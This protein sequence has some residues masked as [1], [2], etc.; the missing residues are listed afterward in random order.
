VLID[1]ILSVET[2][3]TAYSVAEIGELL[4]WLAAA[5]RSSSAEPE[6]VSCIPAIRR[7]E[8]RNH[9]PRVF[10]CDMDLA[11]ETISRSDK[12]QNGHCWHDIFSGPVL[13]RGYPIPRR[14]TLA[15]GSG[16]EIPLDML[17]ALVD[18]SCIAEFDNR[19]FIKGYSAL[20]IPTKQVED[21][22]IWHLL[23]NEDG[24]RISYTDSRIADV[25]P[26][27]PVGIKA[28]R[29]ILGWCSKVRNHTGS[30]HANYDIKWSGLGKPRERHAWEKVSISGGD[31][32]SI[33]TS[34]VIGK[35]DRPLF[36]CAQIGYRSRLRFIA[37]QYVVLY[38]LEEKRAWLVDGLSALLHLV[39]ASLEHDSKDAFNSFFLYKRGQLQEAHSSK[40]GPDAAATVLFNPANCSLRLFPED[41]ESW[42]EETEKK[43]SETETVKEIVS[44]KRVTFFCLKD[45]VLE[46]FS[47]L[48]RIID[49]LNNVQ[50]ETGVGFRL[51][52]TPR[53]TL[54]GFDF[55]DVATNNTPLLPH[56]VKLNI[57][58]SGRGWVDLAR[59]LQAITLFGKG[60]DELISPVPG[61]AQG[62][63]DGCG[64]GVS[65]PVGK[66]YLATCV[67]VVERIL[68]TRGST[69]TVPWR[70]ADDIYW[71]TPGAVFEPCQCAGSGPRKSDRAQVL[72]PSLFPKMWGRGF[73]SPNW[74]ESQGGIIFS[75]N[76][77]V[78]FRLGHRS[79]GSQP[80][81]QDRSLLEAADS[82]LG[83]SLTSNSGHSEDP[84]PSADGTQ[85]EA[86][87]NANA[88]PPSSPVVSP[89]QQDS[90]LPLE[91]LPLRAT[92]SLP[93]CPT[94]VLKLP[95]RD[96]NSADINFGLPASPI[97]RK[98]K[99]DRLKDIAE[100]FRG[101]IR[102]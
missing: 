77:K 92:T 25:E 60:F 18:A 38:D 2:S 8:P 39:R 59:S 80:I 49:N 3:G 99:A 13:V 64:Y 63:C 67:D 5:L 56:L 91:S 20:L 78:P 79:H 101:K 44:K 82:G 10:E 48:E 47:L 24:S 36:G 81:A 88:T 35:K 58:E 27:N 45:R 11:M 100:Q 102:R 68:A 97:D 96:T 9:A 33:G 76:W 57:S 94:N 37:K 43:N 41:E 55:M 71:H 85:G 4:G 62:A 42:D 87:D 16:L 93:S 86:S 28:A 69:E 30:P 15:A 53:N 6:M 23:F 21:V 90:V 1:G 32:V 50:S 72:L 70:L 40:Y 34:F 29:H 89:R 98:R 14:E 73:A 74:L 61:D 12:P 52:G 84:S 7:F 54:E 66:D 51:R 95:Q 19:T 75:H 31:P 83:S 22:I 17:M 65:L 26:V 46:I